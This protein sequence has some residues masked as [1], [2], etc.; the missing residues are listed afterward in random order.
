MF[1]KWNIL[2]HCPFLKYFLHVTIQNFCM[3]IIIGVEEMTGD[4][5]WCVL[6]LHLGW[7]SFEGEYKVMRQR[8]DTAW[9]L[10]S[11]PYID[12]VM[13]SGYRL[14]QIET[15]WCNRWMQDCNTPGN[16]TAEKGRWQYAVL[17]DQRH[18][19][20]GRVEAQLELLGI[21]FRKPTSFVQP[22]GWLG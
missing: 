21:M 10:H 9:R 19:L 7:K 20:F 14:E 11:D 1:L 6:T 2:C 17:M 12:K 3:S 15:L 5:K 18:R 8:E 22:T 13:T 16:S 4:Y